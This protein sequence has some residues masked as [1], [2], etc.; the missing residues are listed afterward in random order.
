MSNLIKAENVKYVNLPRYLTI[1]IPVIDTGHTTEQKRKKML[2]E[3]DEL[4]NEF[5]RG[6]VDKTAALAEM[7]DVLQVMA[8]YLLCEAKEILPSDST[9]DYVETLMYH[10]CTR[11]DAKI[12][13]YA[14]ERGWKVVKRS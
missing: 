5:C 8:G 1:K 11:H 10:A 2:E 13:R 14:S 12:D 4:L 6:D 9:H 7:F 3:L